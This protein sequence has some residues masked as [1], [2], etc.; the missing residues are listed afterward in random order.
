[1]D[2]QFSSF[3]SDLQK[4]LDEKDKFDIK[5]YTHFLKG[6]VSGIQ[7]YIF[8]VKSKNAAKTLK[9]RSFFI[10]A[11]CENAISLIKSKLDE[12]N[13]FI[14]Y[15]GGGNFYLFLGGENVLEKV[16]NVKATINTQL[17]QKEISFVISLVEIPES[18]KTNNDFKQ[19]RQAIE[20]RSRVD[21][22]QKY[23]YFPDAFDRYE[24][25]YN[26]SENQENKAELDKWKD[27]TGSLVRSTS[28]H[29]VPNNTE[30]I[31]V[32]S[33]SVEAFNQSFEISTANHKN[34]FKKS[35]S[36]KIPIA[37][38]EFINNNKD[39]IEAYE[40]A[41]E[42]KISIDGIL[43]LNLLADMAKKRTGSAYLGVLKMDIDDLGAVFSALD[44]FSLNQKVSGAF[45]WFF[46]EHLLNILK[47]GKLKY[48]EK[49]DDEWED[50]EVIY[51]NNV[52]TVFAGGDDSFFIGG[53]DVI[54]QLAIQIQE[55]FDKFTAYL[56]KENPRF[57]EIVVAMYNDKKLEKDKV[58]L[59]AGLTMVSA[60]YPIVRLAEE[61]E[62]LIDEAKGKDKYKNKICVFGNVVSWEEFKEA[63]DLAETLRKLIL[64]KGETRA[65]IYRVDQMAAEFDKLMDKSTSK[66]NE[67]PKV[68]KMYYALRNVKYK[69][70]RDV[71]EQEI[72]EKYSKTMIKAFMDNDY[73]SAAKKYKVAIKLAEYLTKKPE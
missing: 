4:L 25:L 15:N 26:K 53:W 7:E 8:S 21:K 72:V 45:T 29:T 62:H 59:S 44:N 24:S 65:L 54:T 51:Y 58:T 14:Q 63:N 28:W 20:N 22:L 71:I 37:K 68:W 1:M 57:K 23:K 56:F 6:D 2:Q 19:I 9:A 17:W 73:N 34:S 66:N 31:F 47:N 43:P 42:E 27:F 32:N 49:R 12:E 13:V 35:I 55:E 40:K 48:R 18:A 33:N 3:K 61:A 69:E 16:E 50:K 36:N 39:L 41:N 38:K 60:K 64:E 10:Q 5:D 30:Q 46:E 67:I 70:N 11:I 52:Y